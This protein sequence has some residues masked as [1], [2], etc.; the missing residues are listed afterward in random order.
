MVQVENKYGSYGE[1][2]VYTAG[3]RDILRA[4]FEVPL[5]TNNGG[6]APGVL[7]A[8]NG[9]PWSGFAAREKYITDKSEV[10]PLMDGEYY[11]LAPDFWGVDNVQNTTVGRPGQIAQFV[12]DLDYV[13]G[14][15]NSISLHMFHGGTN[16][17]SRTVPSGRILRPASLRVMITGPRWMRA[18]T[19][20]ICIPLCGIRFPS[21]SRRAASP[22]LPI[23][24][25][26]S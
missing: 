25:L 16:S 23:I 21:M 10:G 9:N 12:T 18:G 17:A 14:S 13:L 5:Y 11:T 7:A 22:N 15:N 19:R 2:H 3:L 20:M 1:D 8:I 6:E 26:V 4:Y 24:C